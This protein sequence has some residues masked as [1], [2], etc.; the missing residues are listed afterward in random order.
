MASNVPSHWARDA[1]LS[2]LTTWKIGGPARFFSAPANCEM[3]RED[4]SMARK[5]GLRTLALGGGSNL[6]FPDEGYDGLIIRLPDQLDDQVRDLLP[7]PFRDQLCDRL[8]KQLRE[9]LRDGP[10][11]DLSAPAS[12]RGGA[13]KE[14]I[15]VSLT[16]GV[17]LSGEARRLAGLGWGGLEWAEGIPGT[18]GGAIVNNAGAYGS[19]VAQILDSVLV[20]LPDGT[21]EHWPSARLGFAYRHSCL[22]HRDPTEAFIAAAFIR[23]TRRAPTGL[24]ETMREIRAQRDAK[25]PQEPSCGCVFRNPDDAPAGRLIQELGLSGLRAGGAMV[26]PVHANFI[27]NDR[28]ASAKD[29]LELIRIVQRRV[30]EETGRRLQLEVQLVGWP[31]PLP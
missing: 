21:S 29:V 10:M 9:R 1:A 11:D 16:A 31:D 4:L 26:S 14:E 15:L 22:K 5:M 6:L 23:L 7:K 24:L 12:S 30:F 3:L 25:L 28:R 19:A 20:M 27:V 2:A 17:A 8:P 18:I 13:P